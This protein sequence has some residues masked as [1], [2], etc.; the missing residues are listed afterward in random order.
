MHT[1]AQAAELWCPMSR[2]A[3]TPPNWKA[4]AAPP[5]ARCIGSR[6]A[7]WR[8]RADHFTYRR[9]APA[10]EKTATVEPERPPGVP[11]QWEWNPY[12]EADEE[13]Q[14][15]WREDEAGRQARRIGYCGMAPLA[16]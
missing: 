1:E 15:G 5:G 14:A 2:G 6:C 12:D 16:R 10:N 3:Y 9:F 8:W 11:A 4:I 7:A 13:Y